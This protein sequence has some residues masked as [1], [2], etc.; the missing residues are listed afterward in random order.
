MKKYFFPLLIFAL[1][2]GVG[3][4]L[5]KGL[6]PFLDQQY[7]GLL[8]RTFLGI[9][10]LI[11]T[12][13]FIKDK[14]TL[15]QFGKI[16]SIYIYVTLPVLALFVINNYLLA[17]YATDTAFMASTSLALV[18]IGFIINSF[19]EEF[20]Y[21][22]FIQNYV[23]QDQKMNSPISQGNLFASTLMLISHFGF[24]TVMDL[25]FAISGL[26]LVFIFSLAVGFIRD[27]G[28]SIW[29][30]III[31]TIANGIHLLFNLEHYCPH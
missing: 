25:A 6:E 5:Y 19:Y 16:Q 21:R 8:M 3:V 26:V 4:L 17:Q 29:F 27:R 24:F 15:F 11:L 18:I 9:S 31:H 12:I 22:G 30:L 23:N 13:Q 7:Q 14:K 10:F 28:G 1:I 20:T 2:Q